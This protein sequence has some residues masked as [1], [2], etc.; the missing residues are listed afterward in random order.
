MQEQERQVIIGHLNSSR[1]RIL[2]VIDGLTP[3]QWAFRTAE[4]RWSIAECL[5]HVIRVEDRVRGLVAN[6]LRE[7][8]PQPEQRLSAEELRDKD[9]RISKG[10]VDRSVPR[11]AP[12][13]MRPDGGPANSA[14]LA[15]AFRATRER[16]AEFVRTIEGDLRSHFHA[17]G[18]FGEI[19]CYQWLILM[20][21]H[22]ARHAEQMEE[23]RAS[24]NFPA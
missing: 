8:T 22:S 3:R 2:R 19:D 14:E 7:G 5:D 12:E 11:Q 23:V 18:F 4:G 16:S 10:V 15:A 9:A 17:H 6:K 1:N 13:A 24:Q 20:G 21:L